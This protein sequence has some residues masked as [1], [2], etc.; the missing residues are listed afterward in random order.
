MRVIVIG[1]GPGGLYFAIL[2]KKAHPDYDV[3]VYERNRADD[4]FGFGVVFSDE[5]LDNLM[6]SDPE[7]YEALTR[8]FA[9]WDEIDFHFHAQLVRSSGHGFCGTERRTLLQILQRRCR[10]LGVQLNFE[11]EIRDLDRFADADLV[12]AADGINSL[13]RERYKE[14]FQ[15]TLEYRRNHFIWLGSTAPSAAFNF[16]FATDEHGIWDLCTYQYRS[17]M[18]TWVIE[19]PEQTWQKAAPLLE[20]LDEAQTVAFL[21]R[22]WAPVLD[23]HR[24][25]A[26]RSYWRQFPVVRNAHWSHGNIILLGDALHTAHFSIGSGTKLAMEDAIHLFDALEQ[27]PDDVAAAFR[28]FEQTRRE[29]VE[30]TQYASNVSALWTEN[31]HRYWNMAPVQACFSMLSRAKAVTYENLRL[32]DP[33][34]IERVDRWFAATVREQGFAVPHEP[35]PP[36]FTP[37]RIGQTVVGNRVV[38]SPMN[39]Y[40]AEPGGVPG[41][42][43]LVHLG[44]LAMGGAGLVFAEMTAVSEEAR[45]TPGCPGIYTEQQVSAWRRISDFVHA[46]SSAKLALQL[47][48]CGRKGSTRRGWE[49]MDRPLAEGNWPIVAASPLPFYDFMAVPGEITRGEMDKVRDDFARA[50]VNAVSA[51]FDLLEVHCGHGYLLSGFISPLSNVRTDAYGGSLENRMRF[52]LEVFAAVR[53]SWPRPRPLSVRISATDWADGGITADESLRVAELF[54]QAGADIIDV[55]TG[56]TSRWARPVYG[57]MYQVQFSERIRNELGVPTIAVGAITTADQVNTIVAAGRADLCA[58]ARPHLV[59]PHFTLAA[60]AEYGFDPQPWPA[61]YLAGKEQAFR[62]LARARVETAALR[63]AARPHSH[64]E[65]RAEVAT[66]LQRGRR[67]L[68]AATRA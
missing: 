50:A 48:H 23:G 7:S 11:T 14:H 30:K 39:M 2:L 68:A 49:G 38:V 16:H 61:P 41:D 36:M 56:Q 63:K 26:N 53:A 22:L 33:S 8:E 65:R 18:S 47:G 35:P 45:I 32:R 25:V 9:Y 15:P 62:Q 20:S 6:R 54:R 17:D 10:T 52:P 28:R 55:S 27:S 67:T 58:I 21:E 5:T 12:V 66:G 31:P 3:T 13:V 24:L 40:S 4:T 44:R 64:E 60:S 1:G 46:Q 43:H 51:G 57:R 42:F 19:A 37:F 34:F 59:N 29:D